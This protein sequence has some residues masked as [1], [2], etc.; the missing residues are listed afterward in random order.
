M[1]NERNWRIARVGGEPARL[2]RRATPRRRRHRRR[3]RSRRAL[4]AGDRRAGA[5][6]TSS[7][8]IGGFGGLF[9]LPG[10]GSRALVG[11]TDGVGTKML[12]AADARALRRRRA[13]PRQPLRQ[14]H[15]RRQR[16]AAVLPRL[17]GR[18][19]ARPGRRRPRSSRGVAGAPAARND[20]ALLGGETAEMPGMYAAGD[21]DLAGTIVG[22]VDVD[23]DPAPRAG[24]RRATRSSGCRPV[25]LHTNGYTL[26]RALDPPRNTRSRSARRPTATRCSRRIRRTTTKFARSK[27]VADVKTMAHI[28]GG[29]LLENVPRTLP[30]GV[31]GRLRAVALERPA[32]H[33]G[34]RRARQTRRTRNATGR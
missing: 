6:P 17:S 25:G 11:S 14:R 1:A 34:A 31:Q 2:R 24:R 20:M 15:P 23:R 8:S 30:A 19:Q 12:I 9:G 33:G 18:R 4:P 10:D 29:G 16:D 13:R 5:T 21:F 28:T 26:A 3:K 27:R 32:D 22:V 7:A